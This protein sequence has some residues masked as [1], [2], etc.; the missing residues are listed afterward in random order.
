[1]KAIL[2]VV[3]PDCIGMI[4][5]VSKV[6][7]DNEVNILDISQTRL[8]EFITM[9]MILDI[10]SMKTDFA[11]LTAKMKETGDKLGVVINV[12]HEDIFYSMHRI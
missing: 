10:T 12:Q 6:L 8:D 3:G 7:A 5:S 11:A 9:T 2:T 1:M 4:A